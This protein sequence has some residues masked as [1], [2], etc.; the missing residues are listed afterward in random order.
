MLGFHVTIMDDR[1][2][3]VT[4]ERFP[5]ADELVYGDFKDLDQYIVPYENAYYVIL[6]RGHLGDADCLRRLLKRPYEYLGMIG[7]KNKVRITRENL[8]KEGY[9]LEELDQVHAP[10][11]PSWRT[12]SRGNCSQHY[13]RDCQGE[14]SALQRL[15]R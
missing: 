13:G 8:L 5:E 1:E 10:S 15:L 12:A 6:T 2:D 14:K 9:S 3:F 11:D 7:S 4:K